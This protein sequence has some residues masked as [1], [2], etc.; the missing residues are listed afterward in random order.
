MANDI[1]RIAVSVVDRFKQEL[2]PETLKALSASDF[3]ILTMLVKS[4]AAAG[5][6]GTAAKLEELARDLKADIEHIDI[7]L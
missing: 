1:D 6:E 7:S 3:E 4:A 5:R 2:R